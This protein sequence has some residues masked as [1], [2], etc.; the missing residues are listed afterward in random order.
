MNIDID[1]ITACIRKERKAQYELYQLTYQ[2]LMGIC[3]R[4]AKSYEEAQE[5]VNSGYMKI[6]NNLD[7]YR[8]NIPFKNWI[9]K[10]NG[11]FADR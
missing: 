8:T 7:K 11:K 9:R 10:N 6:L 1:L 5:E 2:Y 4:Y 3:I